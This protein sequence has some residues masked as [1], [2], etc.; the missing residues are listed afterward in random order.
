MKKTATLSALARMMAGENISITHDPRATTAMF[1]LRQRK[2]TLPMWKDMS[3]DLYDLF[4]SHEIGHARE[5]PLEGWHGSIH[6]LGRGFKGYLNVIEDARIERLVKVRFPALSRIYARA[7]QE[8]MNRDFF[9]LKKLHINVDDLPL[10]DRINIRTKCGPIV[11]IRF[12]AEEQRY[13]DRAMATETFAEVE[14]LAE[15]LF[16]LERAK[17]KPGVKNAMDQLQALQDVLEKFRQRGT[18]GMEA[19]GGDG[20]YIEAEATSDQPED[21]SKDGDK[22][23][24]R[25]MLE[26]EPGSLEDMTD[27]DREQ[28]YSDAEKQLEAATEALKNRPDR[29]KRSAG[30]HDNAHDELESTT[31][32]DDLNDYSELEE[33]LLA[34]RLKLEEEVAKAQREGYFKDDEITAQT[35]DEFRANEDSLLEEEDI[36]VH[37]FGEDNQMLFF[38]D[39]Y[40]LNRFVVPV[41]TLQRRLNA[42]FNA[43]TATNKGRTELQ[44]LKDYLRGEQKVISQLASEFEMR[45]NAAQYARAGSAKTG[46]IN[47][48]N[49]HKA[50]FSEDLFKRMTKM[51]DGKSHGMIMYFDQSGSMEDCY[52]RTL[53][54][55]ITLVEFCRRMSIPYAVYGFNDSSHSREAYLPGGSY[56]Y[57]VKPTPGRIQI[58]N[59]ACHLKEYFNSNQTPAEHSRSVAIAW[60][61][62]RRDNRPHHEM[63]HGTPMN[64]AILLS[65]KMVKNFQKDTKVDIVNV[66]F[67][68]DGEAGDNVDVNASGYGWSKGTARVV[69]GEKM[70]PMFKRDVYNKKT[71]TAAVARLMSDTTGANYLGVYIPTSQQRGMSAMRSFASTLYDPSSKHQKR[72]RAYTMA[73]DG[74]VTTA[75]YGFDEFFIIKPLKSDV[76]AEFDDIGEGASTKQISDILT[77]VVQARTSRAFLSVFATAIS[78]RIVD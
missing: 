44:G 37:H 9:G 16:N 6:R 65:G 23:S 52:G 73:R 22:L 26:R 55:V 69:Y 14:Q 34:A 60:W 35:D 24:A 57:P 40:E 78:A 58:S 77:K 67:L 51:P 66:L 42:E 33:R 31:S 46:E 5:T 45:K 3:D 50:R 71:A 15:E 59:T 27:E 43:Y 61:L 11:P 47:I 4:L 7:Y 18:D 30:E 8:L 72:K 20:E 74:F 68:T 70:S 25:E 19:E 2:L 62:R 32:N 39:N 41:R 29:D 48:K 13:L 49:I 17:K 1:D 38:D 53:E 21:D 10:I 75:G 64:Q 56:A 12:T 28:M 36:R 54:Q 63:L 76:D